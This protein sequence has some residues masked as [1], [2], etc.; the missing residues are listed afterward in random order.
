MAGTIWT[1]AITGAAITR[2]IA[3][4]VAEDAAAASEAAQAVAE[5]IAGLLASGRIFRSGAGAPT[6]DLGGNG[7]CYLRTNPP[8]LYGPKADGAW[9]PGVSLVGPTG[10]Q[11]PGDVEGPAGA[12]DGHVALFD[13]ATGKLLR[14]GGALGTAASQN[15]TAF[16]TAAQGAKADT[17]VQPSSTP[18]LAGVALASTTAVVQ[19]REASP[20][21]AT[22]LRWE[23]RCITAGGVVHARYAIRRFDSAGTLTGTPFSIERADGTATFEATPL[24]PTASGGDNSTKG[25]TTAFVTSAVGT[26]EPA[27]AAGTTGQYWRGDKTWATLAQEAVEGLKTTNSPTFAGLTSHGSAFLFNDNGFTISPSG[28]NSISKKLRLVSPAGN[29]GSY[30]QAGANI[31]DASSSSD[32][33]ISRHGTPSSTIRNFTV[34]AQNVTFSSTPTFPTP[35]PGDNSTKAATTA[36]V[37]NAISNPTLPSYT[38]ATVPTASPAGR[39][40]HVSDGAGNKRLAISD[41]TSWRWPDGAVVS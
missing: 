39:L 33:T 15:T 18:R 1:N 20:D 28:G 14:D 3:E 7:D 29:P 41:G 37:A 12:A 11:G 31:N 9:P 19:Y 23:T 40:I 17:A 4:R 34:Y 30:I 6:T 36:F 32:L 26:R 21:D 27:V 38:V 25:A 2:G 22:A 13:G 8:T 10:P 24:F 35:S 16:A 5:A